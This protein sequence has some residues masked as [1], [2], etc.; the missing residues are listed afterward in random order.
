MGS[1][2]AIVANHM[3]RAARKTPLQ[4]QMIKGETMF[5]VVEVGLQNL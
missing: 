5:T 3:K 4:F 2:A 1:G